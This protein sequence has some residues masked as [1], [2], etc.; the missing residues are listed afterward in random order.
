MKLNRNLFKGMV[1]T[2]M[3]KISKNWKIKSHNIIISN[4]G[5]KLLAEKLTEKEIRTAVNGLLRMY[6]DTKYSYWKGMH[7]N[8]GPFESNCD[9]SERAFK[10]SD[11]YPDCIYCVELEKNSCFRV[12]NSACNQYGPSMCIW[13]PASNIGFYNN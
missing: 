8:A 3:K 6:M 11:M 10:G 2:E 5:L 9:L 13:H 4:E 12:N 7:Y 1:K